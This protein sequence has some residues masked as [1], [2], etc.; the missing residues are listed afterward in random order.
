MSARSVSPTQNTLH[1]ACQAADWLGLALFRRIYPR[2]NRRQADDRRGLLKIGH[3]AAIAGRLADAAIR[4]TIALSDADHLLFDCG[5][6]LKARGDVPLLRQKVL[7]SAARNRVMTSTAQWLQFKL[8]IL[9]TGQECAGLISP[10]EARTGEAE[11]VARQRAFA[12]A[13]LAVTFPAH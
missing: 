5:Q 2:G 7:R 9:A 8:G 11:L 12:A 4:D 1:D 10:D 6:L 3:M 13:P